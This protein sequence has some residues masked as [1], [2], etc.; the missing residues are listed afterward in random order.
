MGKGKKCELGQSECL[1]DLISCPS[2]KASLCKSKPLSA[3]ARI[4]VSDFISVFLL[5]NGMLHTGVC[6]MGHTGICGV[7]HTALSVVSVSFFW[8]HV[9]CHCEGRCWLRIEKG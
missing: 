3:I 5:E 4:R 2:L 8:L 1:P 7:G 6:G 9:W